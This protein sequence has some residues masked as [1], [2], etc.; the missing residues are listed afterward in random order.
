M[1]QKV[2]FTQGYARAA[3]IQMESLSFPK[4][5]ED[6]GKKLYTTKIKLV[7]DMI[8]MFLFMFLTFLNLYN[9]VML[10][11]WLLLFQNK[12]IDVNIGI[13]LDM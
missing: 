10:D 3:S 12:L 1:Q 5:L 9:F 11:F 6:F 4:P 2:M 7:W 8:K 13:E